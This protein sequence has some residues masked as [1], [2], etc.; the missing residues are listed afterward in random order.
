M[1]QEFAARPHALLHRRRARPRPADAGHARSRHRIHAAALKQVP[2]AEY[3]PFEC[4]THQRHGRGERGR[5]ACDQ[6][7]AQVMALSTDKAATRSTS[8]ARPSSPR[9]SCSS[10]PT[11]LPATIGTRFAVVR[12]GNVVGSRGCVVPLF[13]RLLAERRRVLPVTDPRMTRFWITLQQ[14]VDFV[15][16]LRSVMRGGEIFVPKIPSMSI[17]D[18]A[19]AMCAGLPT[20]T[21]SASVPARSCTRSCVRWMTRTGP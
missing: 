17:I 5:A 19:A 16:S 2:A 21:S 3:N 18:L 10:P 11:T 14:G 1:Q 13:Q 8:T 6:R 12:Y 20:S 7:R 4:I 15:L 9:T